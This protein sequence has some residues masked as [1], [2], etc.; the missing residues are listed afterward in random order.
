MVT[1]NWL[2]PIRLCYQHKI[3]T[4]QL[5][6]IFVTTEC[7]RF[8]DVTERDKEAELVRIVTEG[9]DEET[10]SIEQ[11]VTRKSINTKQDW[12]S[13]YIGSIGYDEAIYRGE[14]AR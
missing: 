2:Q 14:M 13:Y 11:M 5:A 3:V 10:N 9:D 1:S 12:D 8:R 7:N 4:H 6:I